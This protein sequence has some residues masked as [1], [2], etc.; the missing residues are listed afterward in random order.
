MSGEVLRLARLVADEVAAL[1][2]TIEDGGL[3]RMRQAAASPAP[4]SRAERVVVAG[5]VSDPTASAAL[6]GGHDAAV[7]DELELRH[8]LQRL[9]TV[10]CRGKRVLDRYPVAAVLDAD[11]RAVLGLGAAE[12]G[13][14]NCAQLPGLGGGPRWEP[15]DSRLTNPLALPDGTALWLCRWCHDALDRWGRLPTRDELAT[16]HAGRRVTWPADVPAPP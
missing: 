14:T 13:C 6:A 16:H 5:G 8:I 2:A 1:V 10:A 12:P 9:Y 15:V 7:V 3:Q 4:T 11:T